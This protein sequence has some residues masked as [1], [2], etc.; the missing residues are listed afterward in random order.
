MESGAT[1]E[2]SALVAGRVAAARFAAAARWSTINVRLNADVGG[3]LLRRPPWRLP[4]RDT[5]EL[6]QQLDTG[7]LSARGFDR[8]MRIAWSIADL[9]GRDRP[10]REDVAEAIQ[11]RTGEAS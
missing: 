8:V 11:L 6:Q 5:A 10:D 3:P 1:A 9:D 4:A 2:S 7:A